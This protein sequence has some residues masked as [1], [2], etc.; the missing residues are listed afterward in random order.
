MN[1]GKKSLHLE[2]HFDDKGECN[3][4]YL[5]IDLYNDTNKFIPATYTENRTDALL[6]KPSDWQ[7]SIIRWKIPT[8][9]VPLFTFNDN[10]FYVTL[11]YDNIDYQQQLVYIPDSP[12]PG[13]YG[14]FTQGEF[15]VILN[16]ALRLAHA[17]LPAIP[18]INPADPT[19]APF[20]RWDPTSQLFTVY[21]DQY[22]VANNVQ[23]WFSMYLFQLFEGLTDYYNPNDLVK[24][25]NLIF[26]DETYNRYTQ[27]GHTFIYSQQSFNSVAEWT[28][29]E[30]F[31]FTS[32]NFPVCNEYLSSLSYNSNSVV[33]P[34]ITD[35]IRTITDASSLRSYVVYNPQAEFRWLD[36]T[37]D[38]PFKNIDIQAQYQTKNNEYIN[39]ELPPK[40]SLSMKILFRRK[41]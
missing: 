40:E 34:V 35:F 10:P 25:A 14:I 11:T 17:S 28:N 39:I 7:M 36:L 26:V 41:Y 3:N 32:L 12:I 27:D 19:Q 9:Q 23:L 4:L 30:K 29:I 8:F 38:K 13:A 24:T 31:L 22:Y 2:K 37:G 15:V 20:A 18:N 6:K 33:K 16:N 21:V 1:L 5:N